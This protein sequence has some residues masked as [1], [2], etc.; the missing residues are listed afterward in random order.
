MLRLM[1]HLLVVLLAAGIG[2]GVSH[3][4]PDKFRDDPAGL[5]E[6]VLDPTLQ[7]RLSQND[8]VVKYKDYLVR[9]ML[10]GRMTLAEVADEFLRVNA[11][12]PK[13]L[14]GVLEKYPGANDR[15]KSAHN[16]IAFACGRCLTPAEESEVLAKLS[17]EF[18]ATF[19]YRPAYVTT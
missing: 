6:S 11:E 8:A 1:P 12:Q 17:T 7:G 10:G 18:A 3:L 16:V 9:E 5:D 19:G 13:V 14:A 4:G 15:E 2:L